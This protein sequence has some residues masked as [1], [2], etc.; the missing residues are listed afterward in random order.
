MNLHDPRM[1]R[2]ARYLAFRRFMD[3]C[4]T[5][6]VLTYALLLLMGAVYAAML[7]WAP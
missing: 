1:R 4:L 3:R 2:V 6:G 5:I 7:W